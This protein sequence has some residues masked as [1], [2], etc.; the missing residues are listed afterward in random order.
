MTGKLPAQIMLLSMKIIPNL[1]DFATRKIPILLGTFSQNRQKKA[2]IS[3]TLPVSSF[4]LTTKQVFH[5]S[6]SIFPIVFD[7]V[8]FTIRCRVYQ[9]AVNVTALY[10]QICFFFAT[11]F[12]SLTVFLVTIHDCCFLCSRENILS[13][14]FLKKNLF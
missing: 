8:G 2:C 3:V 7:C 10:V 14:H 5:L 4:V 1:E 12:H 6:R 9:L 13:V 11:F